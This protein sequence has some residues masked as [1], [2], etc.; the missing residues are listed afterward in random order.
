[1]MAQA[2]KSLNMRIARLYLDRWILKARYPKSTG[3]VNFNGSPLNSWTTAGD[4]S[5]KEYISF[6]GGPGTGSSALSGKPLAEN[7]AGTNI[8]DTAKSRGSNLKWDWSTDGTTIEF[9]TKLGYVPNSDTDRQTFLH[10]ANDLNPPGTHGRLWLQ[11]YVPPAGASAASSGF[12]AH[13]YS[14]SMAGPVT[15][16][17]LDLYTVADGLDYNNTGSWAHYAFSFKNEGADLRYKTYR[18]GTLVK[19][20]VWAGNI[21]EEVTGSLKASIGSLHDQIRLAAVVIHP[22]WNAGWF[23]MSGSVD[24]FRYWKKERTAEEI[25]KTLV[26]PSR[27]GLQY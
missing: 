25:G 19:S 18:N 16:T 22:D 14:G 10:L 13:I 21:F 1:M 12:R 17:T 2:L 6:V 3:Y 5:I 27:W 8:Y 9:W 20:A 26:Y 4:P 24:E 11:F 23:K 7:F 15:T